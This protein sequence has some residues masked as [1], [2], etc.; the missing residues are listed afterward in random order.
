MYS[1]DRWLTSQKEG[2]DSFSP[3][4]LMYTSRISVPVKS[5]KETVLKFDFNLYS[6]TDF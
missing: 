5:D 2:G 3:N 6:F 1:N 4:Y